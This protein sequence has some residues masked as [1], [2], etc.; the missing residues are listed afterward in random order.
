MTPFWANYHSH[1]VMLFKAP[2]R[3][4]CLI[5]EIQ[6]HSFAASL[7]ET[8]Q[9][10][11]KTFQKAYACPMKFAGCKDV[12]FAF[13]DIVCLL[14]WHFWTTTTLLTKL[15]YKWAGPYTV[16]TV[17]DKNA[18]KLDLSYTIRKHIVFH[19]SLLAHYTPP[20]TGHPASE[21]QPTIVHNSDEF[22][23]FRILDYRCH[24]RKLL[25]LVQ[26]VGYS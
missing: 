12:V 3:P 25:Y 9:T 21:Q 16:S 4:S 8:N 20:T 5:S 6:A 1:P 23:V 2:K 13:G 22:D 19:V 17:I 24:Y 18:Y 14:T 26:C 11:L 10:H 7:E 15:N